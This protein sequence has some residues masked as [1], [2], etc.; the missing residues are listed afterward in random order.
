MTLGVT[1]I[2][3]V[4]QKNLNKSGEIYGVLIDDTISDIKTKI[5][6]NTDKN[7]FYKETILYYPNLIRLEINDSKITDDS[8]LSLNYSSIPKNPIVYVT[9]IFD[10]IVT[11]DK[12]Y[13]FDFR[14][15]YILQK[16]SISYLN[17][18]Y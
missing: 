18:T 7:N 12:Y 17:Y 9:S 3:K 11:K 10:V 13:D 8:N 16:K 2:D 4:H 5:F 6:V 15:K 1:V 14:S